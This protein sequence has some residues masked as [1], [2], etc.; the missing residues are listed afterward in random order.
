MEEYTINFNNLTNLAFIRYG[1]QIGCG[2]YS[3]LVKAETEL[4]EFDYGIINAEKKEGTL[5]LT[6]SGTSHEVSADIQNILYEAELTSE[7]TCEWCG[8]YTVNQVTMDNQLCTICDECQT[9]CGELKGVEKRLLQ[10]RI[11]QLE[12]MVLN[13]TREFE[14]QS[15]KASHYKMGLDHYKKRSEGLESLSEKDV[16]RSNRPKR[17]VDPI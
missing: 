7:M 4:R 13:R 17:Y 11:Q 5:S 9:T 14:R 1:H 10:R 15:Q 6:V 2:W 16:N 3:I 8:I 12:Q